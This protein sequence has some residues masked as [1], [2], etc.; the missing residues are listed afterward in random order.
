MLALRTQR[1]PVPRPLR[2]PV[3]M[4]IVDHARLRTHRIGARYSLRELAEMCGM[5]SSGK[6]MCS[7]QAI[8]NW[9]SGAT[10]TIP[11]EIAVRLS[12]ILLLPMASVFQPNEGFV[13]PD[14]SSIP[15]NDVHAGASTSS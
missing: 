2:D 3:L 12:K 8:A 5:N 1:T 9:E 11:E 15:R 13:V 7:Y 6:R 4:Q 14:A 10:R